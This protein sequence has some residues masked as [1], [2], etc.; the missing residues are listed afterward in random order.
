MGLVKKCFYCGRKYI[1]SRGCCE[2]CYFE[3]EIKLCRNCGREI[4]LFEFEEGDGYCYSCDEKSDICI[5]LD[6]GKEFYRT[7]FLYELCK[8]CENNAR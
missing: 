1:G 2:K 8:E 7:K 6:C 5:C 4:T 3:K